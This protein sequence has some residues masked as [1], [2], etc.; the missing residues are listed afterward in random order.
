MFNNCYS[1]SLHLTLSLRS[2]SLFSFFFLSFS[3]AR[4]SFLFPRLSAFPLF[5]YVLFLIERIRVSQRFSENIYYAIIRCLF[6]LSFVYSK[7]FNFLSIVLSAHRFPC[8]QFLSLFPRF[9]VF[10]SFY[11]SYLYSL[12]WLVYSFA[13]SLS[14]SLFL[15][16]SH[17]NTHSLSRFLLLSR[18]YI[19]ARYY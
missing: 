10:L 4:T 15:S 2:I 6:V 12:N 11:F 5:Y 3:F 13:L 8:S 18:D 1:F 9:P 17:S 14:L 7:Q 16:H 19:V